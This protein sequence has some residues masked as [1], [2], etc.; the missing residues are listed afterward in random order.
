MECVAASLLRQFRMEL[1][2]PE[3]ERDFDM[4]IVRPKPPCMVRYRRRHARA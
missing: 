4:G 1:V 3:V 2:E